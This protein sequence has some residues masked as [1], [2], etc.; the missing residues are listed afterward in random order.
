MEQ[1]LGKYLADGSVDKEFEIRFA[2]RQKKLTKMNYDNVIRKLKSLGFKL[3]SN[4]P[5]VMMRI[6]FDEYR[7][8]CELMGIDNVSKY[9]K[10]NNLSKINSKFY[11]YI[12]K[13]YATDTDGTV[14]RPINN[15][16]FNFRVSYQTEKPVDDI[17]L[18]DKLQS[19]WRD[20]K[21]TFRYIN[22]ISFYHPDYPYLNVDLSIVKSSR[23]NG[24]GNAYISEFTVD[25]ANVFKNPENYE[26]EIEVKPTDTNNA[27]VLR[28]LRKTIKFV[29]SGIQET[30]YPVSLKEQNETLVNYFQCINS[31]KLFVFKSLNDERYADALSKITEY[32][33]SYNF[34]GPNQ[35]TLQMH[36]IQTTGSDT[37]NINNNYTI[38]EKA[39][40]LRK[41]L[42]INGEGKIYLITTNMNVQFTG[43]STTEK[44][45]HNS[46]LDGEHILYN[47]RQEYIN[48]FAIFDIYFVNGKDVRQ[49]P[50][51]LKDKQ[52]R[53]KIMSEVCKKIV[54][55]QSNVAGNANNNLRIQVK[56]FYNTTAQNVFANCRKILDD[57]DNGT[58]YE[59]ETDGLIFTPATLG[60]TQTK[61]TDKITNRKRTWKLCFKWKPAEFNTIDFLVTT[62]KNNMGNDDISEI[63]N[64]GKKTDTHDQL[65]QYK[66]LNL[67]CGYSEKYINPIQNLIDD[68]LSIKYQ[69]G[70]YKAVKFYPTEPSD[71]E[72]HKCNI[73]LKRDV[74]GVPQMTTEDGEIFTDKTIVEFRYELDN[75]QHWRW[76]PIKV[77][78]DKTAKYLSVER[79]YG[80][81]YEVANSNWK[82]IHNP[83]TREMITTGENIPTEVESYVYY[84]KSDAVS[85]TKAMRN[86]HNQ[87]VKHK[88]ITS[89][90]QPED[91]L[92]DYAVGKA[93]DLPKWKNARLSFVFGIDYAEDNI[94]NKQDG[95]AVRY[96]KMVE[97]H[98]KF[99]MKVMFASGNSAY[100]Y[101]TGEGLKTD[102]DRII[103]NAIVGTGPNSVKQLGK[104][105]TS[106]Y[107]RAAKGF[108]I[109]SCQFAMHYFCKDE[110]SIRGFL[111]NVSEN[112][113]VGGYFIGT[114]Y[115]GAEL[116]KRLDKLAFGETYSI[117]RDGKPIVEITK[118]YEEKEFNNDNTSLGYSIDVTQETI[119]K[120]FRE[121]LVN[122][123]YITRVLENFGFALL[124]K[125]ELVDKELP[126]SV[127]NFEQLYRQMLD[128]TQ[129]NDTFT[130]ARKMSTEE[131]ELSFLNNYFVYKK[132]KNVDTASI[133]LDIIEKVREELS[134]EEPQDSGVGLLIPNFGLKSTETVEQEQSMV[135]NKAIKPKAPKKPRQTK[136]AVELRVKKANK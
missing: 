99:P 131:Q 35:I 45:C 77:R 43:M 10:L 36:H 128:H 102:R 72:A 55:N 71:E 5:D 9:C 86:F 34:I 67:R 20:L 18:I 63:Y 13:S 44:I 54:A 14:L 125:E 101:K 119:G 106:V 46:I 132:I 115:N 19:S 27:D 52:S 84:N 109:S 59:Y 70:E 47:K 94:E 11:N 38:T 74:N 122:F 78:H 50:L 25:S 129:H 92:I 113:A 30:N 120:Q 127:G 82:T 23:L 95:A 4:N 21:K 79:E 118:K 88:L 135:Q 75:K 58:V 17:E 3:V 90:G 53:H 111:R 41:L 93:G 48:L 80:N 98:P 51:Y 7:L 107:G 87:Y 32:Q 24:Y 42:Y 112:T 61:P 69:K 110:P 22:R 133:T 121:Y 60:V 29:L 126:A 97:R 16:D 108:N 85:Q 8:R 123:N 2:T 49:L 6:M 134:S 12:K 89:V 130:T 62:V 104:G 105:V 68:E 64:D 100:N 31:E 73:R 81:S 66:T 124:E 1:L 91:T 65:I 136:D 37:V 26:I 96:L 83:I 103:Y 40:G 117:K 39:D 33:K 28:Q 116:F 15:D 56:T 57:I 114:C 76:I